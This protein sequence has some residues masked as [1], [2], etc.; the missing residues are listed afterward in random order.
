[1]AEEGRIAIIAVQGGVESPASTPAWSCAGASSITGSTL[2]P[3]SVAFKSAVAGA[4]KRT[5]WPWLESGK[6]KPV[7]FEVFAPAEAA[8]A[9]AL[10]ESN[11]HIGK[12]VL[13]W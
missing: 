12:L 2:R 8:K 5:V 6:V 9:H 10:M 4:L 11:R 7:V 1:M 13:T 3:R